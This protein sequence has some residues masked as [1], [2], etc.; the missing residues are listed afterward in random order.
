MIAYIIVSKKNHSHLQGRYTDLMI[1]RSRRPGRRPESSVQRPPEPPKVTEKRE[2]YYSATAEELAG[3]D[4]G[5]DDI[6]HNG[7][8]TEE[9]V[10]A[11]F[12]S[13]RR[14]PKA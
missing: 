2:S 12:D 14:K 10:R 4:S 11:A 3:I 9:E 7:T 5:L 13:F 8:A 1:R 6:R